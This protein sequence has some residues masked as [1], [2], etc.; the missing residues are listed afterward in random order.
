MAGTE[1]GLGSEPQATFSSCFGA[2]FLPLPPSV[3]AR[4]LG[5]RLTRHKSK[6]WLINTGWT[7]GPFG[8][9]RRIRL[10]LTRAMIRAAL[11][12]GSDAVPTRIEPAFGLAVPEKCPGVPTEVL[13]PKVTWEDP[14]A[15]DRQARML[16]DKFIKNFVQYQDE[17]DPDVA[18]AG[19]PPA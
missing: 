1:K 4:L 2:P 12:G 13:D 6:V 10:D 15:Y 8:T 16:A 7:G 14:A 18:K 19:P 9:G 3:Y 17:V 11:S 5:D